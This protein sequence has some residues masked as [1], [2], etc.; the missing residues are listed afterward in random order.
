MARNNN[1]TKLYKPKHL[2]YDGSQAIFN[3]KSIISSNNI[4][5]IRLT[6]F[7]YISKYGSCDILMGHKL[8]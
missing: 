5:T 4:F 3:K 6:G 2:T 7:F 1:Y 8:R